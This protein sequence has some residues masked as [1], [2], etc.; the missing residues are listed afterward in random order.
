MGNR[1]PAEVFAPGEFIAEEL[2]ARNWSQI[3]LA[4]VLGRPPKLVSQLISG[5]SA[6]T[7]ETAKGLGA[8]F[9]TGAEFWMNLERDYRLAHAVHDDAA[10][11]RR[12]SLYAKAPVK[13]MANRGWIEPS[14]NIEVLEKR[15]FDFLHIK[16]IEEE[17]WLAHAA[18]KGA[19]YGEVTTAQW[20]W[21]FRVIQIAEGISVTRYSPKALRDSLEKMERCMFAPEEARH[22]PRILAEC[23]VRLV[24]VER[25][26]QAKI[27]GACCWLQDSPVIGMS[28]RKDRIDNFWFVLRH[29]IEHIL[30][31]DGQKVAII[32]ADLEGVRAGTGEDLP[33]EERAANEAASNFCV[34]TDKLLSFMRRKHPFY[35]EKD[36]VAFAQTVSRH[37]GL[38]IGQLQFRL[39]DYKYLGKKLSLY[40]IRNHVLPG[41]ITD[42]WGQTIRPL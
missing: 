26:P 9:G 31:G 17:P 13:E 7:P 23:G 39:D 20:T 12:S 25:L 41:A 40:K 2:E 4:E 33:P 32:D 10:V 34:P 18:K 5:K 36:V 38:V 42:G 11:E 22:V 1:T 30:R 37:P 6:I 14:E 35:Y 15:V 24:F 16:S 27:D 3:E 21:L 19:S 29:E 28:L 8:A